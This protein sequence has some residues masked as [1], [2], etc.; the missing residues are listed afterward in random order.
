M[1]IYDFDGT[2]N[3]EI[4]TLYDNNGSVNTKIGKVYDNNGS[5]NSLI[6]QSIP[7]PIVLFENGSM[8]NQ[9]IYPI[10][11]Y[12]ITWTWGDGGIGTNLASG[13]GVWTKTAAPNGYSKLKMHCGCDIN[14]TT[15]VQWGTNNLSASL[16]TI[17]TT[18]A[19]RLTYAHMDLRGSKT[20]PYTLTIPVSAT[21]GAFMGLDQNNRNLRI[22]KIWL[23][24]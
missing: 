2:A 11:Q 17:I 13:A 8:V 4:G 23:E 16:P 19:N 10:Y 24:A 21:T 5:A 15:G 14:S 22:W 12:G 7:D 18:G 9:H 6:Y 3:R 1:P 20:S